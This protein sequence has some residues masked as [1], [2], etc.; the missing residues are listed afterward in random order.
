MG[1]GGVWTEAVE[2]GGGRKE[3]AAE[4]TLR[5]AIVLGAVD[6]L[7]AQP[8]G[9]GPGG[10]RRRRLR[11]LARDQSSVLFFRKQGDIHTHTHITHPLTF[12]RGECWDF[13]Y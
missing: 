4:G 10:R 5:G 9:P 13:D 2:W 1:G 12:K 7:S 6:H 8:R 3:G 11:A